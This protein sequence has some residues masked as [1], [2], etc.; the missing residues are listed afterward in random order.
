M[1]F[2]YAELMD[3]DLNSLVKDCNLLSGVF[4]CV[5]ALEGGVYS[6]CQSHMQA[7]TATRHLVTM[8]LCGQ[9]T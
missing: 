5:I 6:N 1:Q 7:I 8:N 2:I 9:Y 4:N 3:R